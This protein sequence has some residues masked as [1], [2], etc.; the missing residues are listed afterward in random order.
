VGREDELALLCRLG[1][2]VRAGLG[3]AV[4]I[5][6]E[7][8]VGKTRLVAE[9][10]TA[11]PALQWAK[12]SCL[13]YSRELAYHMVGDL[14][15]SLVGAPAGADELQTRTA[16]LERVQELFGPVVPDAADAGSGSRDGLEIYAALG[17]LLSLDLEP[18]A[19]ERV[20]TLTAEVLRA[21]YM[22]ALRRLLE[23]LS[24]HRPLALVLENLHWADPSSIDLLVH[25]LPLAS[26]APLLFALVTRPD[27]E[28]PGWQLVLAAREILG[29]MLT[30]LTLYT[31]S[32]VQSRQLV[33]NLLACK[34]VPGEVQALIQH[35]AEGNPLFVEEVVRALI[36][37]G[38]LFQEDGEWRAGT[39]LGGT[40][41][42]DSLQRLL[43]AR[44]DRLPTDVEHAL[45][46]AAVIGRRF[47]TK[48]LAEVLRCEQDDSGLVQHLS[49]L[50][51]AGL[52]RVHQ[53]SPELTYRFRSVLMQDAA[54]ASLLVPDRQ[55][56]HRAVAQAL[57]RLYPEQLETRDLGA[58]LAAQWYAAGDAP[59]AIRYLLLAGDA[60][61]A[62][63]ANQE[64]ESLYR[65]ALDLV[66][67]QAEDAV[68]L[69]DRERADLL[70]GLGEAL[71]RLSRF[72]EATQIWC[73]GIELYR[74][75]GQSEG[76]ARLYARSARAVWYAGDPI[77]S[78]AL[79]QEGLEAVVGAP[80]SPGLAELVHE[81][82]RAHYFT[83]ADPTLVRQLCQQAIE[84]AV[85]LQASGVQ[86]TNVQADALATMGLLPDQDH[87]EA[88]EAL[89]K[90][91]ELAESAGLLS[92]A[93]RAHNN[94][95]AL[96]QE[97]TADFRTS[98]DHFQRAAQISRQVGS[99]EGQM[100][101]LSN[102]AGAA[103][104]VGDWES[105]EAT[106]AERQQLVAR[107]ANPGPAAAGLRISQALLLRYRGERA[108]VLKELQECRLEAQQQGADGH[109]VQCTEFWADLLLEPGTE[110]DG[111]GEP[112][113]EEMETLLESA[114]EVSDR[115][116][117]ED[118]VWL[119]CLLAVVYA[120]QGRI[121][122]AHYQF[123]E[124]QEPARQQPTPLAAGWL[125]WGKARVAVIETRWAEAL[126]AFESAARHWG[127]LGMRWWCARTL[128]E[129]ATAHVQ[130]GEP[131]NLER[132]RALYREAQALFDE[133]GT[134]KYASRMEQRLQ[135][136]NAAIHAEIL[137]GREIAQELAVASRIQQGLLPERPPRLDGWQV[138]VSLQPA[139]ETSG[140]FYD[141]IPLSG[142][143]WGFLVADVA[144]KGVGASLYMALCRTLMR[145]YASEFARQPE[146][147]LSAVNQRML[148]ETRSS[149][150]VTVFY[151]ILD[152]QT[153]SLTY[154]NAGHPPPH[155]LRYR[156]G[157]GN[158]VERQELGRTGMAM[159]VVQ[160]TTWEQC[161]AS[162]EAGDLL[163]L[164]SDGITEAH[165][166]Q[167]ELYGEE[168]L[169][170]VIEDRV[171][172]SGGLTAQDLLDAVLGRVHRFVGSAPQSDD[173]TLLVVRRAP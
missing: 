49:Q 43:Q 33:A 92:Q 1:E 86:A 37:R 152:P 142:G 102:M 114:I 129:W 93:R 48:V 82:A 122:E 20:G 153:A 60:A 76:M 108:A 98:R 51:A 84:M 149:M 65:R 85:R 144:D 148:N 8:G 31:L 18:W 6:G 64:A 159:G 97:Y 53:V 164:Y 41:I 146:R 160:D 151:G 115:L 13:S 109:L 79:C 39:T 155:L 25:L 77:Q 168:R 26:G 88:L 172:A 136:V 47:P 158:Q 125:H 156:T 46:V 58:T 135:E 100:I 56:L 123:A 103:L 14:V 22:V 118:C 95:A 36:D 21:R 28:A 4:L 141:F 29:G 120:R 57:E 15:R 105:A 113:W 12:G 124:A 74:V 128:Y 23:A 126:A 30:E 5:V 45:R 91:V 44:I 59:Q 80:E 78:R 70:S 137:A 166:A 7:P 9:W 67:G 134:P 52:I 19:L 165:N 87:Q 69:D 54:Y 32:D 143:R 121:K 104:W 72:S 99:L 130:R 24:E 169:L 3:R 94:L 162:I 61:L 75:V 11:E 90:A 71:Y 40:E 68:A 81:A 110:A 101:A 34:R 147:V 73:E 111:Q 42:P 107:I 27:R 132:A 170:Q 163:V 157:D 139:R 145:T 38:A 161:S 96:L 17:H 127:R 116:S 50:E 66:R 119:R 106:L 16:L 131:T 83:R 154:C 150:F 167:N 140:D 112:D 55:R 35:K 173:L 63:Y 133:L 62:S 117:V 138:A 89:R 10:S 171:S 2:T